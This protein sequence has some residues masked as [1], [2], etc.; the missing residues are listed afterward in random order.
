MFCGRF[1][2]FCC[3]FCCFHAPP[4][5]FFDISSKCF[6]SVSGS[7]PFFKYC[8]NCFVYCSLFSCLSFFAHCAICVPFILSW[9]GYIV[10][11]HWT[12]RPL[13]FAPFIAAYMIAPFTD[14]CW[15]MSVMLWVI[16][17]SFAFFA[18]SIPQR[19]DAGVFDVAPF[20][21]SF[22]SSIV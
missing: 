7:S 13:S 4:L 19:Y 2:F 18:I 21:P 10:S 22:F 15:P 6:G 5:I 20:Q 8:A 16:F 17:L 11:A 3:F 1:Y 14:V 12:L 9:S